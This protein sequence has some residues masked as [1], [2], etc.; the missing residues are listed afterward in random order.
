MDW[1]KVFCYL[2]MADIQRADISN[3]LLEYT[4]TRD[5]G[6]YFYN[7]KFLVHFGTEATRDALYKE[8]VELLHSIIKK[9][10]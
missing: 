9:G 1:K 8:Q 3:G 4:M 5:S 10:Q 7:D 2:P 6:T